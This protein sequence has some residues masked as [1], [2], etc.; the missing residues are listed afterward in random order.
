M[1]SGQAQGREESRCC[2]PRSE[3]WRE[4]GCDEVGG[5]H[6]RDL[7]E[8]VSECGCVVEEMGEALPWRLGGHDEPR[9]GRSHASV[10]GQPSEPA[11]R[12]VGDVLQR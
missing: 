3:Q 12:D 11:L 4:V 2:G 5:Q 10:V 6:L 8:G 7:S 1:R 9:E